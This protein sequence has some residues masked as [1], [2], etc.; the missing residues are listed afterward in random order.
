MRLLERETGL[1][2]LK[3]WMDEAVA[4]HGR[5]VFVAGEAGIGK[6]A[7]VRVFAQMVE[8]IAR[9]AAGAC[10]PL[11]TPRPLGPLLDV[12]EIAPEAARRLER[13]APRAEVFQAFLSDIAD[14]PTVVIFEDAQWSDDATL[15]LLQFLGR[16]IHRTRALMVVTFRDDEI[17]HRHPLTTVLGDLATAEGVRRMTLSPLSE[18][19][20]RTLAR[21][22]DLDPT[23]LHRRT[24]GNPFFVTEVLA[25]GT[26]GIPVTVRDAVLARASRLSANGRQLL[27][28]AAVV[29]VRF[30]HSVVTAIAGSGAETID[31]CVAAGM[32]RPYD[33]MLAFR[34]ELAREAILATIPPHQ[35]IAVHRAV[36]EVLRSAP[37]TR[38]DVTRLAHHAEAAGDG[39]AVLEYAQEAARRAAALGAHREAAAQY[40]RALRFA[41]DL[42]LE[43]QVGLLK[44]R[45]REC[46]LTNQLDEGIEAM[47]RAIE[48][49]RKLG[50]GRNE[51][52]AFRLLSQIQWCS[53]RIAEAEAAGRDA[54]ARLER[55]APGPELSM[56]YS[57]LSQIFASAGRIKEA[58]LWGRR[59]LE[60]AQRLNAPESLLSAL[61]VV[62]TVEYLEGTPWG[63]ER[64][65]HGLE[66]ARQAGL[67]DY[68]GRIFVSLAL[69]AAHHR[70]DALAD[71]YIEAGL[72][73]C[74][75]RDLDLWRFYLLSCR[76]RLRLDQGLWTDALESAAPVLR[77]RYVSVLPR[78]RAL[79]VL[80][81]VRAR[82]GE[83]DCREP[84]DE[85]AALA[86][87]SG[88]PL[89]IAMV[90]AAR[91]EAAW[92]E[93]RR[94]VV[95]A[96]TAAALPL[97]VRADASRLIGELACWRWRAG[98]PTEPPGKAAR[99]YALELAGEWRQAADRWREI[100]CP[101]E[102]ALALADS[103]E[104]EPLRQ[105]LEI[106]DRLGARPM[107]A[108]VA[109]RLREMGIRSIPRGPRPTTRAHPA[110]LTP[111]EAEIA[112]L[113]AQGLRN[114]EIATRMYISVKTVDHHVSSVLAKLGARNR[115]DVAREAA[116]LGLLENGTKRGR[117]VSS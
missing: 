51:G 10:D 88:D 53:G 95:M 94:E 35:S 83:P 1:K 57:N 107:A 100:G 18:G 30:E 52:D 115:T 101:Y 108:L 55:F 62:G 91:A 48:H 86:E 59:A 49:Y 15:D 63:R 11:S 24:G 75:E 105:A 8:G 61:D 26:T 90:A 54:V 6:T 87:P 39:A 19:A 109:R 64:L 33:G 14:V 36:L 27:E 85:A 116:M 12:Q 73:Y 28:T 21:G 98:G 117:G 17:D 110:G 22:S 41:N 31:E 78:I 44:R 34:H 58:T 38:G 96:T 7:L 50:D 82:R 76:A 40:A 111:R 13:G 113:V 60:L 46:Y 45:S 43:V 77:A 23:E 2:D 84:L 56:A 25:S 37:A 29:G 20:V 102:T 5:L 32:L 81:L 114:P 93:G 106:F 66:L 99:P 72:D 70:S 16:R 3:G 71:R 103:D 92:L 80:G 104:E 112:S 97:A 79:L 47:Q 65:E 67:D 68:V 69:T 4:G 89:R 9:V 42:P 74:S